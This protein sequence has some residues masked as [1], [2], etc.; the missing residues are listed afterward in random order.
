MPVEDQILFVLHVP[1]DASAAIERRYV[2]T[3]L[4]EFTDTVGVAGSLH[5]HHGLGLHF[6]LLRHRDQLGLRGGES[7]IVG[8]RAVQFRHFPRQ[9]GLRRLRLCKDALVVGHLVA[10]HA[11][12]HVDQHL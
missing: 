7:R 3:V 4:D 5:R 10:T 2:I 9:P 8:N 6:A 1:D 11:R 12:T